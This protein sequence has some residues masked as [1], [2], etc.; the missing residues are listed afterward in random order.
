MNRAGV[1]R[2]IFSSS[3]ATFGSPTTF[4]ITETS[5]QRPTNPYGQAKLQAEQAIVAF[6]KAKERQKASFSA[7]LLRYFNV[8]GADPAGRMGPHLIHKANA[9]FP[10]ILDAIYD[11][12]LGVRSELNVTGDAFPTKD[13]SA[14]RD[15]IHVTD[16]VDAHVQLMFALK[17]TDLLY[18][19]VGN[20]KPY[21]VLEI[22][23]V[24]RKV[25]G[26]RI[27]VNMKPARPGDPGILYTDPAKIKYEI[28][29]YAT[30]RHTAPHR[31]A[32]RLTTLPQAHRARARLARVLAEAGNPS[33]PTSSRWCA[34]A[35]IGAWPT[36]AR[37]RRR[38]S[39]RSRT[40]TSLSRARTTQRLRSGTTQRSS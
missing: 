12:A 17:G 29:W 10:R 4:P 15:Y 32:P 1:S 37:R 28:G 5:P 20:G 34:T 8:V 36:T 14:Q 31:A 26:R 22:A 33:T 18:Y 19:N 40:I 13:G 38:R 16:L 27:P 21:T 25:T 23:E 6:L 30:P 35:G 7:A 39:T 24:A 11:V 3:C 9:R 2:L